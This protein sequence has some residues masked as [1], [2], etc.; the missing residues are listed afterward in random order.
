MYLVTPPTLLKKY[1]GPN[2]IWEI[3]TL[4]KELFLTFDDGPHPEITPIVL[5]LLEK[6]NAKATFFCVGEN[7]EKYP[8]VYQSILQQGHTVG[9]HTYNHFNGLKTKT[10]TYISN[11]EKCAEYVSSNLFRPPYGVLKRSQIKEI[12]TDYKIIMWN[13]LSADY[14]QNTSEEGCWENVKQNSKNGSIIVF[15]DSEKAKINM[16]FAL[17]KTLEYFSELEFV[18]KKI[19][20]ESTP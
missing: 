8:E 12:S 1:Y 17:T 2:V 3:P 10:E 6:F 4:N 14:D 11:I 9:N 7:V 20:F 13:T 5:G 18:F 19:N 16:L 15:H